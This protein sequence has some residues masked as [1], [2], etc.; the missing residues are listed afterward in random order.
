MLSSL[1]TD[2]DV[3]RRMPD[4]PADTAAAATAGGQS[5]PSIATVTAADAALDDSDGW[6]TDDD[7]APLDGG[8]RRGKGA[9]SIGSLDS[10]TT[11][12]TCSIPTPR[13][14]QRRLLKNVSGQ[15]W[16]SNTNIN[17]FSEISHVHR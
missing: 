6:I 9:A 2:M 4:R 16:I 14:N 12:S 17:M 3:S 15:T 13:S 5:V 10:V 11:A 1:R 7:G 8:A